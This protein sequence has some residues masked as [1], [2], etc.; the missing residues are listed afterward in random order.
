MTMN[1]TIKQKNIELINQIAME[2]E[3]SQ[4]TKS[5][6]NIAL[7]SYSTFLGK[8]LEELLE[9]AETEEDKGIRWKRRTLKKT[10]NRI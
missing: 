7:N 6:Y 9:E 2:R 5:L 8:T 1:T 10:L 3:L 4:N